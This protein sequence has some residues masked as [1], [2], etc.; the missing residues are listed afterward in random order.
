MPSYKEGWGSI[1]V[2]ARNYRY[3][4]IYYLTAH[5]LVYADLCYSTITKGDAFCS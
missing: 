4:E 1:A 3:Y 2:I 5:L